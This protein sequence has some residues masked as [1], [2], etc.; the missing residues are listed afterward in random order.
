LV[1]PIISGPDFRDH[2]IVDAALRDPRAVTIRGLKVAWFTALGPVT[3]TKETV[4]AV[5]EAARTLRQGGATLTEASP[6][7]LEAADDLFRRIFGA[8]GGAGVRGL[9][10]TLGTREI[11]PLLKEAFTELFSTP[12][13]SAAE[14]LALI[15]S[16]D[17]WRN[18][19]LAF[20]ENYDAILSPVAA[21]PAVLHGS[22]NQP[23][24]APG[25]VYARAWNLTG[26]PATTVRAGTSPE[27]LPIGIQIAARPWREDVSLALAGEVEERLGAWPGPRL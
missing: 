27:G 7:G 17:R 15:T 19:A 5:K 22:S 14:L 24:N 6:P 23:A 16:W 20:L 25:F 9:L 12:A 8:D 4:E 18:E 3:P 1:L 10:T 21:F 13:A 2:S 11:S 26:W